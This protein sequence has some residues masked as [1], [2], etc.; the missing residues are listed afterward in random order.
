MITKRRPSIHVY[1]LLGTCLATNFDHPLRSHSTFS[2][3][4][5]SFNHDIV[6]AVFRAFI[7]I[8]WLLRLT[9]NF[10][11]QIVLKIL[12]KL[13]TFKTVGHSYSCRTKSLLSDLDLEIKRKK[14]YVLPEFAANQWNRYKK[15]TMHFTIMLPFL[16]FSDSRPVTFLRHCPNRFRRV[17]KAAS[18]SLALPVITWEWRKSRCARFP[19]LHTALGLLTRFAVLKRV[20]HF[21][22][23]QFRFSLCCG[24]LHSQSVLIDTWCQRV[25]TIVVIQMVNA[26]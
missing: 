19:P 4:R 3:F 13:V 20:R 5:L 18:L 22:S 7:T 8:I 6:P 2:R 14:L 15:D 25:E 17:T 26:D 21:P 23:L 24:D 1:H 10:V 9:T 12:T 16:R 11:P